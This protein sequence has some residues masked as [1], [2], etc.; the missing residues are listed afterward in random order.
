MVEE[1]RRSLLARGYQVENV[2]VDEPG[3]GGGVIDEL[4]SRNIPVTPYN[5]GQ[6]LVKDRDPDDEVR[7]FMNRRARDY[8][9][10][11]RKLELNQLPLPDD[12]TLVAQAA[13]IQY[14]YSENQ[15]IVIESKQKLTDR[16]GAEASPD[17]IDVIVMGC[18]PWYSTMAT[19][20]QISDTDVTVG[21][22][23]PTAIE[24]MEQLFGERISAM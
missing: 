19:N 2:I 10:V 13:S 5:G 15:K 18:A 9:V 4:R 11:R 16:L 12:D 21:E 3:V 20:T 6:A 7:M 22:D 17:R 8:W 14:D 1:K 23:R 24:A